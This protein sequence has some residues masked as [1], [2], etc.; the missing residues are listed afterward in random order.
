MPRPFCQRRV[1]FQPNYY[2]FKPCGIHI[3]QSETINLTLDELE[4]VRLADLCGMYQEQAA[5]CMKVS[6]ATF[7]RIIE[8]A[9]R[10]I[11]EALIMGKVLK[12]QRGPVE[13]TETQKY[14]CNECKF[15]I[16]LP[17]QTTNLCL[18]PRCGGKTLRPKFH[19][20]RR[21]HQ[22]GGPRWL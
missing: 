20:H 13:I 7:G 22:R 4:A 1:G 16:E 17:Y 3:V 15:E 18:C 8:S 14:H 12:F 21:R 2:Y 9:H 6:R 11:A 10:K 5:E 19:C